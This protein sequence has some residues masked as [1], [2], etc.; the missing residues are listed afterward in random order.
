LKIAILGGAPSS[1]WLAPYDDP[2]WDI[3]G[4]AHSTLSV[5]RITCRFELHSREIIG[6]AYDETDLEILKAAPVFM[7]EQSED[8]PES[9]AYPLDRIVETWGRH[10]LTSTVAYMLALAIERQPTHIGIWGVDMDAAEEYIYQRS[11]CLY[12]IE[13]AQERGIDVFVPK[14]ST[15]LTASKLYGY[16]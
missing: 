10:W 16:E 8:Y 6:R 12:F 4:A 5:P 2:S 15:L 1:M 9:I 13:K 11:G 3:W 14:E 7:Q